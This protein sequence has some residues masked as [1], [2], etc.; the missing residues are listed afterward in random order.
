[1]EPRAG[2]AGYGLARP[3]QDLITPSCPGPDLEQGTGPGV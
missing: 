1:M 3:E 2:S